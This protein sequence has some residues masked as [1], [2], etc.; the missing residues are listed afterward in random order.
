VTKTGSVTRHPSPVKPPPI[1][2]LGGTFD[3]IHLGHLRLA[4]EMVTALG[5]TTLRIMPS[6]TPPHRR[7]PA[8]TAGHRREMVARAIADNPHFVMEAS[9]LER[10]GPGYMVDT[11]SVLRLEQVPDTPIILILGVDAFAGLSAWHDW[12]RLF[13]LC[14]FAVAQRPGYADWQAQL[15]PAL[16]EAL[17][18]RLAKQADDLH[19]CPAG[20]ILLVESTPLDISASR[21]RTDLRAGRS[22]RYLLPDRVLEYI[23]TH[24]L[25]R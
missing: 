15:A 13:E 7:A 6:G 19:A 21:I 2:L 3:P 16:R 8:A 1:G 17:S 14:H 9:E 4:E 24:R 23:D 25:Y 12:T 11:L 5:L 20:R 10:S 18:A 22:V